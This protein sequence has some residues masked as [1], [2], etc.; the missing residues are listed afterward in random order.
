M[1]RHIED[2]KA[3]TKTRAEK[4]LAD[5]EKQIKKFMRARNK[6]SDKV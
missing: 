2:I 4:I 3:E 6:S 1:D 5:Q